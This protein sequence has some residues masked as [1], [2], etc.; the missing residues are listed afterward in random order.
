MPHGDRSPSESDI[1]VLGEELVCLSKSGTRVLGCVVAVQLGKEFPL[2]LRCMMSHA[3][4]TNT[5]SLITSFS[6]SFH[7]PCTTL[8]LSAA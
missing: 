2:S 8:D 6:A 3:T 5:I 1:T 7:V 4:E